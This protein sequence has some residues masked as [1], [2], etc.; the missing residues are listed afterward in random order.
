MLLKHSIDIAVRYSETDA[1]SFV[2]HSNYLTYFELGRTE[3]FRAQGGSY[4]RMEEL[5]LFLVVVK[6]QVHYRKPARFDDRLTLHTEV[7]RTTPA[8]V[9]H[10]YHLMR[11][12]EE[13]C[14]ASSVIA[15]VGRDGQPMRIP[16]NLPEFAAEP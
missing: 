5:G 10:G 3:L 6:F 2:H 13:I 15:C 16:E 14:T 9:E 1:M 7:T 11:G 4:R 8:R 12:E